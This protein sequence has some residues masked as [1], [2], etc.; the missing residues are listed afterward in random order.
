MA[1]SRNQ[2]Q[3]FCVSLYFFLP[4]A[5][6]SFMRH[7]HFPLNNTTSLP[8]YKIAPLSTQYVRFPLHIPL[9][10][11]LVLHTQYV[12]AIPIAYPIVRMSACTQFVISDNKRT[13][14]LTWSWTPCPTWDWT[15]CPQV[16]YVPCG[17]E[18]APVPVICCD[19][20]MRWDRDLKWYAAW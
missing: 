16:A 8:Y 3:F 18:Q 6:S 12:C 15:L 5:I 13:P 14:W 7:F 19:I 2:G 9:Y 1:S 11:R 17:S 4:P 20:N 10:V